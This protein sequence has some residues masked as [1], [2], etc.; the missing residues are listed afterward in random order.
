MPASFWT[1]LRQE[2]LHPAIVHFPL[3]FL[4]TVPLLQLWHMRSGDV[5]AAE[6]ASFL[7]KAGLF[8][9][10]PAMLAGGWDFYRR[11]VRAGRKDAYGTATMHIMSMLTA[12]SFYGGSL[13][14][15]EGSDL[16]PLILSL[17]GALAIT[18]GGW[19]GGTLVYRHHIGIIFSKE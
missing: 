9:S 11:I 15:P 1:K 4:L 10:L 17:C 8:M 12:L 19:L 14:C 18:I 2:P 5:F 16:P 3:A 13:L 7:L 6:A